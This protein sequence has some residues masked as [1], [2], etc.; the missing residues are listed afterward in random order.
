MAATLVSEWADNLFFVAGR[1]DFDK[2][3]PVY[4]HDDCLNLGQYEVQFSPIA[5]AWVDA[6]DNPI[7]W[8]WEFFHFGQE[9]LFVARV[10]DY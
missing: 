6:I 3:D 9:G 4:G 1:Q 10:N 8:G 2:V 7:S 5:A